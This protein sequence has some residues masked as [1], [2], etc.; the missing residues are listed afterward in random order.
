VAKA[1][2]DTAVSV[3]NVSRM[4]SVDR[5]LA[6]K[7]TYALAEVSYSAPGACLFEQGLFAGSLVDQNQHLARKH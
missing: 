3:I 1:L 4:L 2:V 5:D 7:Y 6:Q